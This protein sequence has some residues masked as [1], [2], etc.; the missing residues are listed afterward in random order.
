MCS[1]AWLSTQPSWCPVS[2]I[3]L[4]AIVQFSRE[5]NG[6]AEHRRTY[7]PQTGLKIRE[8]TGE[9]VHASVITFSGDLGETVDRIRSIFEA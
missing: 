1:K 8:G 6:F 5:Y 2:D 4:R 3:C 9:T 7:C